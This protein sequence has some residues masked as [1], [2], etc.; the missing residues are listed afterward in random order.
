MY[1]LFGLDSYH[2]VSRSI[3]K[4]I[5]FGGDIIVAG[6]KWSSQ[7]EEIPLHSLEKGK[8]TIL[9]TSSLNGVKYKVKNVKIVFE[10]SFTSTD[11]VSSLLS[12]NNLYIKGVENGSVHINDKSITSVKGEYETLIELSE[13]DKAK[14]FVRIAGSTGVKE[15]K[16]PENTSSF[17]TLSEEKY[18]P[19]VISISKDTE[20]TEVYEK[21]TLSIGKNSVEN[22]ASVQILKLRK[23]DYPAI[24][25]EIK[26]M[27]ANSTAYRLENKLGEFTKMMTF[28][29]PYDEKKLGARSAKELKAFYFDYTTKKW[30]VD[31]TS[32]VDTDKKSLLLKQKETPIILME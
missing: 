23:K 9:F 25:G 16:I 21:A 2:S 11:H 30:R 28:S 13:S 5:A 26:N 27:T 6:S 31:P 3:N 10:N 1:D 14:G 20:H 32:K 19:A 4:N 17:K 15:Y 18:M 22:I 8:N 7:K 12:G 29:F 24:S